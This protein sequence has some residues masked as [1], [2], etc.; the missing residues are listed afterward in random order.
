MCP[1]CSI[2]QSDTIITVASWE[3]RFRL[4]LENIKQSLTPKRV[5]MFYYSE[6][7]Q[8]SKEN[9]EA[10]SKLFSSDNCSVIESRLYFN[11]SV[12]TWNTIATSIQDNLLNGELATLDI[13]TRGRLDH[14]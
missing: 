1:P 12:T 9:R 2:S 6:Y 10:I 7:E 5:I 8:W 13:S 4:G 14:L 11:N 3:E